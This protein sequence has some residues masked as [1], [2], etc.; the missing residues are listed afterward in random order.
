MGIIDISLLGNGATYY[1][2]LR[3]SGVHL[4]SYDGEFADNDNENPDYPGISPGSKG[5]IPKV[6]NFIPKGRVFIGSTGMPTN[7]L[8]GG[9]DHA[10]NGFTA[11]PRVPLVW[12]NEKGTIQYVEISSR[13]LPC[14]KNVSSWVLL[15]V[16][17]DEEEVTP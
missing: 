6:Y 8:Y 3:Q 10:E 16:L 2:F 7:L 17:G 12:F 11:E 5:F 14:P 13:P 4:Y 1:G 9:I 15:D